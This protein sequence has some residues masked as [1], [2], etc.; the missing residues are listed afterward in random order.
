MLRKIAQPYKVA[1]RRCTSTAPEANSSKAILRLI[2]FD[3]ATN[4]QRVESYEY[5]KHHDYMVLDLIT[6][7]KAHQDPTLAFRA[8]CC[9]GVCGSCAMNINGINSLACITFSQQVT[10]VG[11]LPNF[12]VIKDFVVDLRHFFRQYAYIRP[13][14]RNSNLDRSR[15]DNIMDRYNTI[16]KTIHGV[17]PREE[18]LQTELPSHGGV[19]TEV[20]GMLRL[21]DALC[22][23]GD[24]THIVCTLGELEARGVQLDQE[25]VKV[26]LET[27]LQNYGKK[28]GAA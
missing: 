28:Q 14:V 11:P 4:K 27:A 22:E 3:P 15:V 10:T 21:L 16:S 6:A 26:L 20:V 8:S 18:A 25:K 13:F 12:P 7:V 17:S 9:E 1:I 5:D 2:R 23:A 19:Q 24:V